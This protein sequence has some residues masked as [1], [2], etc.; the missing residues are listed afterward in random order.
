MK[1]RVELLSR[2]RERNVAADV[3]FL[4]ELHPELLH[5]I[6]LAH[7]IGG[8]RFIS[9]DAVG[10]Q[11]AGHFIAVEYRDFVAPFCKLG[12]AG[13]RRGPRADACDALAVRRA[14]VKQFNLVVEDIV[15]GV[16]L[17]AADLDRLIA[18][19]VHH[20]GAFAKHLGGA[21]AAAAVSQDVRG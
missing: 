13:E 7:R 4:P 15:D 18:L 12:G 20:A 1:D 6:D 8:A 10:V 11:A 14:G 5:Q 21:H 2:A 3:R 17:Q 19:F 9:G 16:A